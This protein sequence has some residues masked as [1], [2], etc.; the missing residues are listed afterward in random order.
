MAAP[1]QLSPA[2]Y[3]HQ[4]N[5]GNSTERAA[6]SPGLRLE[7]M[8]DLGLAQSGY[9]RQVKQK[10]NNQTL[11]QVRKPQTGL[12]KE[13]QQQAVQGEQLVY[14]KGTIDGSTKMPYPFLAE[15]LC[16]SQFC[17]DLNPRKK[18]CLPAEGLY[19]LPSR[20]KVSRDIC[21][22][23]SSEYLHCTCCF[24]KVLTPFG[25]LYKLPHG[26]GHIFSKAP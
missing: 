10:R 22:L 4:E 25:S 15:G 13:L 26:L 17:T 14:S 5:K 1:A 19:L 2:I 18:T 7:T 12:I 9:I 21:Q 20:F 8:F 6:G 23:V 16:F 24:L 11:A 3:Q